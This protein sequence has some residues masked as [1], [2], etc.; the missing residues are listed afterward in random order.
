TESESVHGFRGRLMTAQRATFNGGGTGFRS[1]NRDDA[2][3]NRATS[4]VINILDAVDIPIIVLGCDFVLLCFNEAAADL[5]RL[6]PSDVGRASRDISALVGLPR[7]EEQC[8]QVIASGM[9][10]RT[11]FRDGDK[12]F[13]MRISPYAKGARHVAGTVV[14]FTNVTA[15]RASIDQ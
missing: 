5:L 6:S 10:S 8:N 4:D 14:T 11:D 12:S 2:A 1:V 13:V 9:E 7:L 3:E 15:L